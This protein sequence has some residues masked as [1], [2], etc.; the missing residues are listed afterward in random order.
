MKIAIDASQIV[1]GT[2]VS[3]YTSNLLKALSEI[4]NRDEFIVFGSSL[5]A[6]EKLEN[7]IKDLNLKN[8]FKNRFFSLPP[9]FFEIFWNQ[10]HLI[11]LENFVGKV[12]V[13]H[14]SDWT[15]PPAKKAKL[16]TTIHDLAVLKYPEYFSSRILKNQKLRLEWIK[17]EADAIIAVSQATKK[18]IVNLLKIDPQKIHVI[19]EAVPLEHKV[20]IDKEDIEEVKRKYKLQNYIL[21]VGT[22]EPRK[23]LN[24]VIEAFKKIK[25][26]Q[27]VIVGKKGW[28]RDKEFSM[29]NFQ[30]SN[31]KFLDRV[32]NKELAIL[33]AG[34]K[35]FV[36]P[37]F[38]EGFG[39][40]V[41]EA[42]YY[43]CPVITSNVS[44]LPEIVGKAAI[45]VNPHDAKDIAKAIETIFTNKSTF[46]RLRKE[47]LRQVKK[48][49]WR[50]CARKTIKLYYQLKKNSTID[51]N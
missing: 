24:R 20:K 27:L 26:L 4:N 17:K 5:R 45:L 10:I 25:N 15:Q 48:F 30:F 32:S 1:F 3:F 29:T 18:D 2:G 42:M 49:S 7:K 51:K 21:F 31:I 44:S 43:G 11:K 37:S 22:R 14:T 34:A 33:Y 41:L 38:Y 23:N 19:Y 35:C 39:L 8:N 16:V 36:Y 9:L 13:F 46:Y 6:R 40:P 28:G 50:E 47:G 12:D